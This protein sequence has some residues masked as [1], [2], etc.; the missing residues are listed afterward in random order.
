MK[1][2]ANRNWI[3]QMKQKHFTTY[4]LKQLDLVFRKMIWNVIRMEVLYLQSGFVLKKDIDWPNVFKMKIDNVSQDHWLELV[5][6]FILYWC[7]PRISAQCIPTWWRNCFLNCFFFYLFGENLIFRKKK[8]WNLI[9]RTPIKAQ[10]ILHELVSQISLFWNY[11]KKNHSYLR[12][13]K[14]RKLKQKKKVYAWQWASLRW[15]LRFMIFG[16]YV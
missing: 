16:K 10:F 1:K 3:V 6:S 5:W 14:G 2:R 7:G 15:R 9:C 13:K 12:K 8:T 11:E 4:M